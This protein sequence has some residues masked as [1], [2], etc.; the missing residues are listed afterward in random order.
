MEHRNLIS[1]N[2]VAET[3][4]FS[5]AAKELGY[6]QST[7]TFQIKQLEEELGVL[8][9]DRIGNHISI[10]QAGST[11]LDYSCKILSLESEVK[12]IITEDDTPSGT[13]RIASID[14]LC[15][16]LL[17]TLIRNFSEL[18][19]AVTIS[20][21]SVSKADVLNSI[22]NGWADFGFYIDFDPPADDFNTI[23]NIRNSLS[24]L[25][26][27]S[28][29]VYRQESL[30]IRELAGI[31]MIVTEKNCTY[32]NLLQQ[33]FA[34]NNTELSVYFES[35]NTEVIKHFAEIG[36]GIT[37]LPEIAVHEELKEQKLCRLPVD[38]KIPSTYINA[39]YHK[40][41]WLTPAMREFCKVLNTIESVL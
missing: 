40:N 28:N 26:A 11:L 12:S 17:P 35:E 14:S 34:Q 2:M 10:T 13:I 16:N 1:F 37:F 15:A 8:L 24:F 38:V 18:Y 39:I 20:A 31:P 5:K 21:S 41:K 9:F 23:I 32:R 27:P 33:I 4:S 29:K 22:A 6:A 30:T 3:G 36:L 7:I 19:P 25:C